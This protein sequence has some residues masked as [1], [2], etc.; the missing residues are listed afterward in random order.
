[1][2]LCVRRTGRRRLSVTSSDSAAWGVLSTAPSGAVADQEV[3]REMRP[4]AARLLPPHF[5]QRYVIPALLL[6]MHACECNRPDP[7]PAPITSLKVQP[8]TVYV[9]PSAV[10]V[11]RARML[12]DLG[13]AWPSDPQLVWT[14]GS[15]LTIIGQGADSVVLR[16][17]DV[18]PSSVSTGLQAQLGSLSATATITIL[19]NNAPAPGSLDSAKGTY[20]VGMSP[21][22]ML[23]N[24]PFASEPLDDALIAFVGIGLL[25]DI[26]GGD[27]EAARFAT[28]QAFYVETPV[29]WHTGSDVIDM[30]GGDALQAPTNPTFTIWIA[31]IDAN[32]PGDA[33]ADAK[34]AKRVFQREYTGVLLSPIQKNAT[35]SGP[36]TLK[37][38]PSLECQDLITQLQNLG[39][40]GT[41]PSP[42]SSSAFQK[43]SLNVVYVDDILL[44][45]T[46]SSLTQASTGYTGFTCP[47]DQTAGTVILI[48]AKHSSGTLAHELG[49]AFGLQ[50]TDLL[51]GFSYT[52]MMQ[53]Q[54]SDLTQAPRSTFSL[55][56]AFRIGIDD[57]SW[58]RFWTGEPTRDCHPTSSS[59][60]P[61]AMDFQ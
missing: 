49:H 22:V 25:G 21:D 48:A 27:G 45:P 23:L 1:M 29:T 19:A 30:Q 58:L 24:A 54:E 61:L 15:D 34:W 47:Q 56:Q 10:F 13:G 8:S 36:F 35:G 38:G 18:G 57:H 53:S 37:L 3:V 43:E 28:D 26:S 32:A 20:R 40:V 16:A 12:D 4:V 50:H 33:D 39:L 17:S 11:M 7:P 41:S 51:N 5:R 52:N 14:A 31:T 9:T 2:H 42:A 6:L 46:T 55:G 44:P 59:C 60:P